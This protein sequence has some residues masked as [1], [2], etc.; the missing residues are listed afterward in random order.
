MSDRPIEGLMDTTLDKIKQMVDV[1]TVIGAPITTPN[2]TTV[3]PVSKV[4]YGFVS[5]GSEFNPKKAENKNLFGGGASAGVT[6]NPI[7]FIA[8]T[9]DDVKLLGVSN[10]KDPQDRAVGMVPELLDKILGLFKKDK[11]KEDV[12]EA[13]ADGN[14]PLNETK[15]ETGL[16][17]PKV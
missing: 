17:D 5:G 9:K 12:E 10:F 2:G 14:L 13:A 8:V 7:A 6:I 1:N 15:E 3:I 11:K 16:D 4:M